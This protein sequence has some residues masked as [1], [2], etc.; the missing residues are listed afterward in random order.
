[1]RK[2][3]LG[4]II[5]ENREKQQFSKKRYAGVCVALWHCLDMKWMKEFQ[6]NFC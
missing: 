6:T 4:R 3:T 1:M 5:Q 2:T